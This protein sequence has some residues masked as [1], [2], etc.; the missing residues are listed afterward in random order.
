MQ[1]RAYKLEIILVVLSVAAGLISYKLLTKHVTG[2]SGSAWFDVG[3]SDDATEGGSNCAAVLTSPYA[4]WPPKHPGERPGRTHIPVAFFGLLYYSFLAVWVFVVGRP[5]RSRRWIHLLPL[6][7]TAIGLFC[8]FQFINIMI[9]RLQDWCLW[10]VVTHILNGMIA[11]G[12][13][14]L[15][16]RRSPQESLAI[17]DPLAD[18]TTVNHMAPYPSWSR[19]WCAF[20]LMLIIFYGH[21]GEFA[22]LNARETGITLRQCL[23]QVALVQGEPIKLMRAWATTERQELTIRPDDPFRTDA[24]REEKILEVVVFSDFLCPSCARFA[25]FLEKKAQPMFDGRLKIIYRH[26]PID[27]DC[28]PQV[29]R[30]MHPGAC[31]AARIAEAARLLGGRETFWKAHDRLYAL[32][33]EGHKGRRYDLEKLA[34][35]F[36][37]DLDEMIAAMNAPLTTRRIEE[38]AL[39]AKTSGLRGT[40]AVFIQRKL[41]TGLASRNSAF[42][43]LMA[44]QFWQSIGQPRP[45][46][47][48]LNKKTPK[49]GS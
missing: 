21:R 17:A 9:T 33:R 35:E 22:F 36:G 37:L 14:L 23:D 15:W 16:P 8:S 19:V 24:T 31:E 42:W 38:D 3:C 5:S 18:P 2:D 10:C 7:V 49:A 32:Q 1:Y 43:N 12:L 44:D 26:Y 6:G 41:I 13:L 25:E 48:K 34:A 29:R 20:G 30:T 4:Y 27:T 11:I 46:H 45:E 47:T 40:P 39:L 28:N